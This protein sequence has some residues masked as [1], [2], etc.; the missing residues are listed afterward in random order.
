MAEIK[1]GLE[2][3]V[4][5]TDRNTI[6][7]Y[8]LKAQ[9]S[10][11]YS[12]GY[13]P[14]GKSLDEL[15]KEGFILSKDPEKMEAEIKGYDTLEKY[16][17]VPEMKRVDRENCCIEYEGIIPNLRL[18]EFIRKTLKNI[19]KK[20]RTS[21]K[22]DSY[23]KALIKINS[24]FGKRLRKLHDDTYDPKTFKVD[25]IYDLQYAANILVEGRFRTDSVRLKKDGFRLIDY[26]SFRKTNAYDSFFGM[27]VSQTEAAT[28]GRK[29]SQKLKSL[30]IIKPAMN[31]FLEGYIGKRQPEWFEPGEL[32]R[33]S[34][35]TSIVDSTLYS[36][37]GNVLSDD[38]IENIK[39]VMDNVIDL[40]ENKHIYL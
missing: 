27:L 30:N 14:A 22:A 12:S 39:F 40:L 23:G 25:S 4:R 28:S 18:D 8:F 10:R 31:A 20:N 19:S 26:T 36:A 21:L 13:I 2:S 32:G 33:Y 3:R 7:K 6:L 15:A 16:F 17:P 35:K 38:G 34:L 9:D 1:Q 24:E 11:A 29:D 37:I 5:L